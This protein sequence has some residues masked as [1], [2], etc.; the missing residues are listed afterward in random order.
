M[1]YFRRVTKNPNKYGQYHINNRNFGGMKWINI[2]VQKMV[3]LHRVMIWIYTES[4]NIVIYTSY[5]ESIS[6]I[7]CGQG[8]TVSIEAIILIIEILVE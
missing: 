2:T 3:H 1:D 5:F 6:R 8:Y 4:C 7:C